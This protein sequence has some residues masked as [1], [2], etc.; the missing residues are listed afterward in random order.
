M[1]WEWPQKRQKDKKT[2]KK[3]EK[4]QKQI[5][6]RKKSSWNF[7]NW[8]HF[9]ELIIQSYRR[10]QLCKLVVA[11]GRTGKRKVTKCRLKD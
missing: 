9:N 2:K 10:N 5:L 1:L 7:E 6:I 4:E 8:L 11:L 3:I